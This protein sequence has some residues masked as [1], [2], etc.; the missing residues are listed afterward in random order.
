[1]QHYSHT[2]IINKNIKDFFKTN[3]TLDTTHLTQWETHKCVIRGPLI[4]ISAPHKRAKQ[5]SINTLL[6]QIQRLEQNHKLTKAQNIW[7]ELD[8]AR[9]RLREELGKKTR[10]NYTL[11]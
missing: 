9:E 10:K 2:L 3:N 8:Q 1:M 11:S 4:K 7:T 6:R 5:Q